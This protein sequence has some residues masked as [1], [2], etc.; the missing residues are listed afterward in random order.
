MNVTNLTVRCPS[1]NLKD[2]FMTVK[3]SYLHG[4]AN[5]NEVYPSLILQAKAQELYWIIVCSE[6]T[7]LL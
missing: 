6:E 3:N 1:V 2:S 4:Y 5:T 7:V